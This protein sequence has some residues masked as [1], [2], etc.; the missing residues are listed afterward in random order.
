LVL[1]LA[2]TKWVLQFS[3][4]HAHLVGIFSTPK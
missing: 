2:I 3:P 1:Y 4:S